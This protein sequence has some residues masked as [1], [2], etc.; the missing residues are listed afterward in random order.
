MQEFSNSYEGFLYMSGDL[1]TRAEAE[2]SFPFDSALPAKNKL[3]RIA[4]L[5]T[6]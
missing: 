4:V 1:I 6:H 5:F 2:Q 3:P